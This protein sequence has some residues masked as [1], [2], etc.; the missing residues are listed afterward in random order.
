M[1]IMSYVALLPDNDMHYAGHCKGGGLSRPSSGEAAH[2]C[3]QRGGHHVLPHHDE[4]AEGG[5]AEESSGR[6][7]CEACHGAKKKNEPQLQISELQ[8]L[9]FTFNV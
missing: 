8:N 4:A 6:E 3:G 9:I 5:A 1:A 2:S 7:D